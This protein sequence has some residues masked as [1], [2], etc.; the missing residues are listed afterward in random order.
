MKKKGQHEVSNTKE[1]ERELDKYNL[2]TLASGKR[3][4]TCN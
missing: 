4:V 1:R 3:E 2:K